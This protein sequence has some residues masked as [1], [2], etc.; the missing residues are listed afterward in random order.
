MSSPG[1]NRTILSLWAILEVKA[2]DGGPRS[3]TCFSTGLWAGRP[4]RRGRPLPVPGRPRAAGSIRTG[5]RHTRPGGNRTGAVGGGAPVQRPHEAQPQRDGQQPEPPGERTAR[6]G[7]AAR[8]GRRS[9]AGRPRTPGRGP[10][11][12]GDR[13]RL[14]RQAGPDP[15]GT[16]HPRPRDTRPRDTGRRGPRAAH[17][18]RRLTGRSVVRRGP[19]GA[20]QQKHDPEGQHERDRTPERYQ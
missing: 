10:R 9:R 15:G 11:R 4:R 16:R 13:G 6:V 2:G 1:R 12:R 20:N 18:R 19:G 17:R 3:E 5:L 14:D 8:A 7:Q